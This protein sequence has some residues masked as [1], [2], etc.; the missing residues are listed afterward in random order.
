MERL[1]FSQASRYDGLE[2]AI[3]IARY[4]FA[5]QFCAG[6]KVLDVACGEGYGSHL[7]A[8][9]GATDVVGVDVAAQ[10]VESAQQHF[11]GE[12]VRFLQA[13]GERLNEFLETQSFDLIISFETIEHVSDPVAFLENIKRLLKPGGTI[14]VSCPNDWWY[15][16]TDAEQNPYH[17]RKYYFDGFKAEAEGVLGVATGW[18]L[19]GPL[20]GFIN[21]RYQQYP[22]DDGR[23]GQLQMLNMAQS[24]AI[25]IVPAEHQA[26]PEPANASYFVG[27]WTSGTN[28]VPTNLGG[29][30]LPLSM[31]AFRTGIFRGHLPVAQ[32]V[33]S[34]SMQ[35]AAAIE[36]LQ[37]K[38]RIVG[39]R[40]EA[41]SLEL[42]LTR[43]HGGYNGQRLATLEW[44]AA[45]YERIHRAVPAWLRKAL[46]SV[47]RRLRKVSHGN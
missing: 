17:Q 8:Q 16:P 27:L 21:L 15:Y 9:W 6:K 35:Q 22:S 37:R 34:E 23:S 40:A 46:M 12:K 38:L 5:K 19:G 7:L 4:A 26:G 3:H 18:Y 29:A 1:S 45:R 31:D 36:E 10:A 41:L 32:D 47:Y 20:T 39:L 30:I 28:T 2:A 33:S 42:Q 13:E 11:G 25:Q 44:Q 14:I 24:N 43:E